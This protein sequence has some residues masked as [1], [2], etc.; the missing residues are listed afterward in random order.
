MTGKFN[1]YYNFTFMEFLLTTKPTMEDFI[2]GRLFGTRTGSWEDLGYAVDQKM[3]ECDYVDNEKNIKKM[4]TLNLLPDLSSASY[5]YSDDI[6]DMLDY[7][8]SEI[9]IR[10]EKS[11]DAE[12]F[13]AIA[14]QS[15]HL[16]KTVEISNLVTG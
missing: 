14:F 10:I 3:I 1:K 6:N 15:R 12:K 5:S 2:S 16:I 9:K 8:K 13:P 7:Y 11:I 4:G